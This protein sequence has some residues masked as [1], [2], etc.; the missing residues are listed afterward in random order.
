MMK[1]HGSLW[2]VAGSVITYFVD[3]YGV[4]LSGESTLLGVYAGYRLAS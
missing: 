4:V 2:A 1:A 3:Q